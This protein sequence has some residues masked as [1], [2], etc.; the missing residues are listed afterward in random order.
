MLLS[1][2]VEMSKNEK[3]TEWLELSGW[4]PA[5]RTFSVA[6]SARCESLRV[7]AR[8]FFVYADHGAIDDDSDH[9]KHNRS[10]D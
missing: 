10:T 7:I 1:G 4:M 2:W 5:R 9:K 6:E 8:A 3:A